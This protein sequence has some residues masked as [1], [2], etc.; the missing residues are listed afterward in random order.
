MRLKGSPMTLSR[1][2]LVLRGSVL[3]IH[4]PPITPHAHAELW[5]PLGQEFPVLTGPGGLDDVMIPG[6]SRHLVRCTGTIV[7]TTCSCR[8]AHHL[9]VR[10]VGLRRWT[11]LEGFIVCVHTKVI[12]NAFDALSA[13]QIRYGM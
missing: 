9:R 5:T 12:G 11:A 7:K 6:M 3:T 13:L 8:I 4:C 2:A 10:E 1:I